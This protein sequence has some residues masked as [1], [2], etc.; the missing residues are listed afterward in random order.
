VAQDL[1][2]HPCVVRCRGHDFDTF[3]VARTKTYL[4]LIDPARSE[5]VTSSSGTRLLRRPAYDP[6]LADRFL[7][8]R[9]EQDRT[10]VV[11]G[12]RLV[13]LVR[14]AGLRINFQPAG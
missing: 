1:E 8:A 2:F 12:S 10:V 4:P 3:Q 13:E 9:D 11:C 7:V 14:S 6:V 5:Y